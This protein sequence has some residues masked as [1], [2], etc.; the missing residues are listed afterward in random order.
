MNDF[1]V[2]LTSHL[3]VVLSEILCDL[4][5]AFVREPMR[6]EHFSH[7]LFVPMLEWTACTHAHMNQLGAN[8]HNT[9]TMAVSLTRAIAHDDLDA[10]VSSVVSPLPF[11][12]I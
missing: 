7:M 3:I 12:A 9:L 8:T 5:H 6:R 1:K 11:F 4:A 10:A 2:F